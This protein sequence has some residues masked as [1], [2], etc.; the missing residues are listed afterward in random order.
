MPYI[1]H[2]PMLPAAMPVIAFVIG[3]VGAKAFAEG[4]GALSRFEEQTV[5]IH[6]QDVKLA[7]SLSER[8]I[9]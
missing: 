2:I 6:N 5:G 8:D 7:G 3:M 1:Y 4:S 9:S